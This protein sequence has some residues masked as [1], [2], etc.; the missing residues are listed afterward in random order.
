M[1]DQSLSSGS[2]D[3]SQNAPEQ[4]KPR[5]RSSRDVGRD[6]S[7][8]LKGWDYEPGTINVRKITGL[9]GLP[10]IQMRLDLGVLQ[11]EVTGRPD[12]Q[13]PH[14]HESL[15]ELFEMQLRD[16]K[17]R[18]GTELGF[19][20]TADQCEALREEAEM[21][22]RRYLS[23]FVLGD[24]DGVVS[25]TARNIRVLDMCASFGA[26]DQDRLVL[27]Q[28]RPYLVMMHTRAAASLQYKT[29]QF[30]EALK[31]V[32][33]GLAKIREFFSRFDQHD[34]YAE[35]SEVRLLK[36]FAREIRRKLPVDPVELLQRKLDRAVKDE[37]YE[38]AAKLRD[39]INGMPG[40]KRVK[41]D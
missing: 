35:S 37:R 38:E 8:L 6:I 36:K 17:Q 10:K 29:G 32:S 13:R 22:Y 1:H 12:G 2:S 16:H 19:Q 21:Y 15:L 14:G 31:T 34:A 33:G 20:L 40:H 26:T 3:E 30:A 23:L 41:Q 11:M 5:R 25:D 27:E 7:P 28:F 4:H 18:N 24:F 9:D 39:Q